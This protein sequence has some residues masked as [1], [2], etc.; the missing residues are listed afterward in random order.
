VEVGAFAGPADDAAGEDAGDL[1]AGDGEAVALDD[2]GVAF[3][4][5]AGLV[6]GC[7]FFVTFDIRDLRYLARDR[8]AV[9]V[10]VER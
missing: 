8:R 1:G 10:N 4:D 7:R 6:A 2:E 5:K 9:D 3:V